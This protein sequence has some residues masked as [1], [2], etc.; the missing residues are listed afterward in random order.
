MFGNNKK[1]PG[2]SSAPGTA[3]SSH[4]L[5]SL[6]Q[7]TLVEGTL[8]A[9][10]DIRVDGK[11][12]GKLLCA[13]KVILG[14]SGHIEGEIRCKNAVI[15]GKFSGHLEV[16]ELLNVRETAHVEGDVNVNKLIIQSGAVFNVTC[17]MGGVKKSDRSMMGAS[18]VNE[19]PIQ[20]GKPVGA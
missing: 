8:R 17:N 4:S 2:K 12:K 3:S 13:A 6:T 14:P 11:I 16:E 5:N 15:E 10:S 7:G 20:T 1:E 19:G 9:D 18:K